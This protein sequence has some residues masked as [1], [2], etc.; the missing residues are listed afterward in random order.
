MHADCAGLDVL[1]ILRVMDEDGNSL[2]ADVGRSVPKDKQHGVDDVGFAA[3]IG[4]HDRCEALGVGVCV[5]VGGGG[6]RRKQ[7]R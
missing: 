1:V 4:T 5:R 7:P 3:T 6:G 2:G